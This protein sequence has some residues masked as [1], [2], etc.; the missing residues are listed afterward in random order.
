MIDPYKALANILNKNVI[1]FD[2]WKSNFWVTFQVTLCPHYF[3]NFQKNGP[4]P[5]WT[6][7]QTILRNVCNFGILSVVVIVRSL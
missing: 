3:C 1:L 5:K 6:T 4:R 7:F 2:L